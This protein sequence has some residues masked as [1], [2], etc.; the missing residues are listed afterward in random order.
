MQ[1]TDLWLELLAN[2]LLFDTGVDGIYLRSGRFEDIV[3]KVDDLISWAFAD[4]HAEVLYGPPVIPLA[5]LQ[6]T[7]Y[8]TRFPDLIGTLN[9]D[10]LALSSAGCQSL[11]PLCSGRLPVGGRIVEF[12]GHAFRH[13][14]SHDPFRMQCFRHHE[15]IYLG[16]AEGAIAFR[17]LLLERF[18]TLL[19][20]LGLDVE[21]ADANDPF[22]GRAGKFMASIQRAKALK[23]ELVWEGTALASFNYHLEHFAS[24]FGIQ[25]SDGEVAH[26]SCGGVGVERIALALLKTHGLDPETWPL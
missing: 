2:E 7:G 21:V 1:V 15:F 4:Q 16:D 20:D 24:E 19:T 22:F 9:E 23:Y 11:Y 8:A 6:R 17:S 25:T 3:R 26:T 14:P 12:F 18:T 5:V 13:E 10:D